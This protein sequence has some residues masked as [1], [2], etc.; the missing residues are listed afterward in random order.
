MFFLL[1]S[2]AVGDFEGV[3]Y[4]FLDAGFSYSNVFAV[5]A[6]LEGRVS[7]CNPLGTIPVVAILEGRFQ[8]LQS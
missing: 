8:L 4:D 2:L 7:C 5:V 3:A 6:I 1:L